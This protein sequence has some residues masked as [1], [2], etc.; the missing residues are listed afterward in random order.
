MNNVDVPFFRW[1]ASATMQARSNR[2]HK[3]HPFDR[4]CLCFALVVPPPLTTILATASRLAL[5]GYWWHPCCR[6]PCW[7]VLWPC[8]KDF[9]RQHHPPTKEHPPHPPWAPLRHIYIRLPPALLVQ[10]HKQRQHAFRRVP[11]TLETKLQ[12]LSPSQN[13]HHH[14]HHHHHHHYQ[15]YQHHHWQLVP[16]PS[17]STIIIYFG[18]PMPGRNYSALSWWLPSFPNDSYIYPPPAFCSNEFPRQPRHCWET[19]YYPWRRVPVVSCNS[20]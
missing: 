15:H 12:T 8:P 17:H 2:V 20:V 14:H 7:W 11:T 18:H 16:S 4:P 1:L 19:C 6:E 10:P 13:Y 3:P 5:S 9:L